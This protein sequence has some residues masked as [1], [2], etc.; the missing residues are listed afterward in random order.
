MLAVLIIT[1]LEINFEELNY[2]IE[3][4]GTLST[5]IRFQFRGN[6]IPFTVHLCRVNISTAEAL[7]L[8]FFIDYDNIGSDY[9]QSVGRRS[10]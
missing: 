4:G 10:M 5:G 3:E 2:S 9:Y 7:D 1:G 6:Q 8:G